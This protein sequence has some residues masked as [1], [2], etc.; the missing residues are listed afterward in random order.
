M[1]IF[2]GV[3]VSR[4]KMFRLVILVI[5]LFSEVNSEVQETSLAASSSSAGEPPANNPLGSS[6]SSSED[7]LTPLLLSSTGGSS[8]SACVNCP[9]T[10]CTLSKVSYKKKSIHYNWRV[11]GLP[12]YIS[13]LEKFQTPFTMSSDVSFNATHPNDGEWSFSFSREDQHPL[14]LRVT[15]K[16]TT[17]PMPPARYSTP[18]P[19]KLAF[20]LSLTA[21]AEDESVTF[22][23][24]IS[25]KATFTGQRRI[26][27]SSSSLPDYGTGDY[28]RHSGNRTTVY[29][30]T[31]L[32]VWSDLQTKLVALMESTGLESQSIEFQF[33]INSYEEET[34]SINSEADCQ[35]WNE[36]ESGNNRNY[37]NH[38]HHHHGGFEPHPV[39]NA[40]W[41]PFLHHMYALMKDDKYTDLTVK[42]G[43]EEFQIHRVIA[44]Y[45]SPVLA[46]MVFNKTYLK[47]ESLIDFGEDIGSDVVEELIR[48]MYIG[49]V[50]D[51]EEIADRLIVA[52]TTYGF[53]AL[54]RQC[55]S[56]L[57]KQVK[58][59][60]AFSM[61]ALGAEVGS[62]RLKR[63]AFNIMKENK[64]KIV[65]Q[66]EEFRKL[67]VHH[68]DVMYELF[69]S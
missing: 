56:S 58:T 61:Y 39:N 64:S 47:S 49:K 25:S 11:N 54:K 43:D 63:R 50:E 46:T 19:P 60:N 48:Y 16:Y 66:S 21:H 59:E 31:Y 53:P 8:A 23:S 20:D 5:T 30:W 10:V 9:Q 34:P 62:M 37:H 65:A 40:T 52:S 26:S 41:P 7:Q 67:S 3:R 29:T 57:I 6:S 69:L 4:M 32:F 24:Q 38:H 36:N 45:S 33:I 42:S 13:Y 15:Y 51:I 1:G 55:E 28:H 12:E 27:Q 18:S 14:E 17:K 22:P 44:A 35:N 2:S 68:P